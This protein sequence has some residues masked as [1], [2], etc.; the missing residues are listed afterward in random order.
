MFLKNGSNP[1]FFEENYEE[2]KIT[3]FLLLGFIVL[4]VEF[5][6]IFVE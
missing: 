5:A 3:F 6:L 1:D 4:G 2:K